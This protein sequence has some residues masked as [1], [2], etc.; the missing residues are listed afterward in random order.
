MAHGYSTAGRSEVDRLRKSLDSLLDRASKVDS[1]TELAGD[2]NRFVTV[3]VCGFLEQSLLAL[4]RSAAER[5]ASTISQT[6]A[7]SHLARSFNPSSESVVK[8]V[9]RF[10]TKWGS[11]L[12]ALLEADERGQRLNSLVGLRNDIAH[13]KNQGVSLNQARGYLVVVDEVVEWIACRLEPRP[14]VAMPS[15]T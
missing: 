8:F 4:G 14:G 12:T 6:F 15:P 7:A 2:M 13:G 3:R 1:A 5:Y 10:S 9:K 11:E